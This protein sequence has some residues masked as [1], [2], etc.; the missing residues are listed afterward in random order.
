MA[1][2]Y[3]PILIDVS[4][5]EALVVGG[6]NVAQRKIETLLD[7]DTRVTVISPEATDKVAFW[8]ENNQIRWERH[9]YEP[10]DATRFGFVIAASDDPDLNRRVHDDAIKDAVPVNV[11][12]DPA[13]CDFIFPAITKRGPLTV[14]VS[15]DGQAPFLSAFL[16]QFMDGLFPDRYRK[17]ADWAVHFRRM[18]IEQGPEDMSARKQAYQTFLEADWK[19]MLKSMNDTQIEA[20]LRRWAGIES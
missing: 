9:P 2:K 8:A 12:D 3:L 6:G 4:N 15:S 11:V 17:I 16:R 5:R 14:S 10:G 20:E 7:Y 1:G 19:Q 18:V 13:Y